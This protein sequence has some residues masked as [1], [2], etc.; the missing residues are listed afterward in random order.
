MMIPMKHF[1]ATHLGQ[2]D[3]VKTPVLINDTP[4]GSTRDFIPTADFMP[5]AEFRK[6]LKFYRHVGT[7][8]MIRF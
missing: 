6:P 3:K 1:A 7:R 2:Y 5:T 8:H 4:A